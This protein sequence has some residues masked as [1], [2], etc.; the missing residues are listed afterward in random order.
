MQ[1]Y[2]KCKQD[3]LAIQIASYQ[4]QLS[5]LPKGSLFC[6]KSGNHY[7]YYQH[8]DGQ[9]I[10]L[11]TKELPR[12][13][14]LAQKLVLTAKLEDTL[15]EKLALDAYI[16]KMDRQPSK[17]TALLEKKAFLYELFDD[18][19]AFSLAKEQTDWINAPYIHNP[20]HPEQLAIPTLS[21][22]LVRSNAES[23]IAASLYMNHIP[24]R[25]ECALELG[26]TLCFP[27]F[28]ILHPH[29]GDLLY[30]EHF[31]NMNQSQACDHAFYKLRLYSEYGILPGIKLI[32]TFETDEKPLT[33]DR[34]EALLI[35]YFV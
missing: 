15:S 3:Y 24:Y 14:Q 34:M 32:T 7:K 17:L 28:T 26:T 8:I 16:E 12:I 4:E 29:T 5:A 11:S 6:S 19:S 9:S 33:A 25:Y 23:L 2:F 18:C 21:K 22:Q 27:T 10:Y 20:M 31:P 1:D 35:Q 13:K 30:W